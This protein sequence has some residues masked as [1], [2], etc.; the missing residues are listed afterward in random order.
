MELKELIDNFNPAQK[1]AISHLEGPQLII[2]GAGSG[3]TSVLTAR[4]A[5]LM[6]QGVLPESI[7]ALTFTKKAAGEMKARIASF[8]GD[9]ATRLMMGTFHSIFARILRRYAP[10]ISFPSN[11]TILDEDDAEVFL[12]ESTKRVLYNG[13]KPE[14]EWTEGERKAFEVA[15]APYKLRTL[16][17][18]FSSCKN[19]L[20]TA[21]MYC[22]SEEI[23]KYDQMMKRPLAGTIFTEYRNECHRSAVM[24][25]DDILLYTDMLLANRPDICK[26]IAESFNYILVDEYQDTNTAQY[27]ILKHLTEWNKN[28]CVVG[29]DSQSIY[30]FRGARIQNIL[31][32]RKDYPGCRLVK[33]ERNYRSTST[34]VDAAN[35]L[36]AN[37]EGRIEKVCFSKRGQGSNIMVKELET[38]KGEAT[39]IAGLIAGR[40]DREKDLR[41]SD[42][43]VLYRTNA[44]S[45]ELEEALIRRSIPYVIYSGTSFF[46]RMEV[47][48]TL[49]YMKLAVNPDD[50]AAFRRIINK[51]VRGLG[52]AAMA[53]LSDIA[54][55][56]NVSLWK[57]I[58]SPQFEL[59]G[60]YFTAR[61]LEGFRKF[62]E[63]IH[64]AQELAATMKAY[65]AASRISDLTGF[66]QAY[67]EEKTEDGDK[68]ADN[69]RELVDAAKSYE[70]DYGK[71]ANLEGFLQDVALLSN[72][73]TDA[74]NE[75]RVSLM[76]VHCAKGLEYQNVII[77]GAEDFLF[78][79]R[80]EKTQK[81]IE[82]E[83]RLFY[84]AVTRAKDNLYITEAKTRIKFGKWQRQK[85]SPFVKELLGTDTGVFGEDDDEEN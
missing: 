66:Y 40:K 4:I 39:Y 28:I 57:T 58:D 23:Q 3:K 70:Q 24:D 48:D 59:L 75:D 52:E 63:L 56:W 76:T 45:R 18:L 5:L 43:A 72:A 19:E 65:D 85:E 62:R 38:S 71:D 30:A 36:I 49:A 9:D 64:E 21:D 35:R 16:K 44:Q 12:K 10:L 78:P 82:E 46:D 74:G 1:E 67:V 11:F 60:G 77:A 17:N 41:W 14:S 13:R 2:A 73:D 83:R 55:S 80:I 29:D 15:D 27:S 69:I 34:I 61:A 84:V 7:L 79:L 25:Y 8:Q 51:P 26:S 32:F 42:F 22:R 53:R 6:Q 81:E 47:K 20:V 31:N 37:N 33:L 54:S 50:D 68:R